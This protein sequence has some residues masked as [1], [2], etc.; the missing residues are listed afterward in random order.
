VF[1]VAVLVMVSGAGCKETPAEEPLKD[2]KIGLAGPMTGDYAIWGQSTLKGAQI[3]VDEFN[4]KGG[5]NGRKVVLVPADDKG[6]PKEGATVAQKL[7]NDPDVIAIAG[8]NFSAAALT[9]APIY[10]REGLPMVGITASNPKI[11]EVGDYIF[12]IGLNDNQISQKMADYAVLEREWKKIAILRENSDYGLAT[13]SAFTDQ[14]VKD[15]AEITT[16]ETYLQGTDRDFSVQLTKIRE[17]NPDCILLIGF[18]TE[19]GLIVKQAQQLE[20]DTQLYGVDGTNSDVFFELAGDAAEGIIIATLFD[21]G[22][23]E[24]K[25]FVEKYEATYKESIFSTCPYAYDALNVILNALTR[26]ESVTRKD[27]RDAIA[28]TNDQNLAGITGKIV[29]AENGGRHTAWLVNII[30][31][32]GEI[33]VRDVY[34]D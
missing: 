25:P 11:P 1:L 34:V 19:H 3:A 5:L 31:E 10:Q 23:E 9:A 20:I 4:E 16:V 26:A 27:V 21:R 12:T 14:A 13:E 2:I 29:F 22:V 28:A 15:G 33:K 7:V 30:Y 32:N 17:T 18:G 24:A 6:D 8:H